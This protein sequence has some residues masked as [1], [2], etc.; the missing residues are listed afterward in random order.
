MSIVNEIAKLCRRYSGKTLK[1]YQ[2]MLKERYNIVVDLSKEN[3]CEKLIWLVCNTYIKYKPMRTVKFCVKRYN[4]E[5]FT[6]IANK[7]IPTISKSRVSVLV[8]S[9]ERSLSRFEIRPITTTEL[10]KK[11][12][13]NI[14]KFNEALNITYLY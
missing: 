14:N 1:E 5:T 8:N 4:G 7:H 2:V 11:N 12:N 9:F 13:I 3:D 10:I 6:S